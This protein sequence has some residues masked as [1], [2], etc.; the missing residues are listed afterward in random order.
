MLSCGLLLASANAYRALGVVISCRMLSR[1]L[2]LAS[3]NAYRALGVVIFCRM[4]SCGL[5]LASANA[6]RALGVVI[7]LSYVVSWSASCCRSDKGSRSPFSLSV[8]DLDC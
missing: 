4:L 8:V 2:L 5:L 7:V 3:A 1:G 6:Y